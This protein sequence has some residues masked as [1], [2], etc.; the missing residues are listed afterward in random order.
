ME[1][2]A[3]SLSPSACSFL[4]LSSAKRAFRKTDAVQSVNG[5][6]KTSTFRVLS[7]QQVAERG[8]VFY[9][10]TLLNPR[11][12]AFSRIGYCPQF[13]ALYDELTAR[14]HLELLGRIHGYT[15]DSLDKVVEHLLET[16]DLLHYSNT[17]TA[18]F[19]GGTKRKLLMAQALIGDPHL[20][21]LDE[22][23]TGMDPNSR[24]Y[25]WEAVNSFV[26]R[27][28]A[29]V[30][31][32]HSI[33]ESEAL[34]GKLAIMEKSLVKEKFTEAFPKAVLVEDHANTLHF[35]LPPP[36]ILSEL[37][38]FTPLNVQEYVLSF[39]ISQNTLEQAFMSFVREQADPGKVSRS[40]YSI[41]T[42]DVC[43]VASTAT[44]WSATEMSCRKSFTST[45]SS[46]SCNSRSRYWKIMKPNTE[47]RDQKSSN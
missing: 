23:T 47:E 45:A 12:D 2:A 11:S 4:L 6:G 10:R 7:G 8:S 27:G 44:E 34:C 1:G 39:S 46:S 17:K 20:L 26:R 36:C 5:A 22:P 14:E 43:A 19:S 16:F 3:Y 42:G 9:G 21:L 37:F 40:V 28:N 30:L 35:E 33:P 18:F 24:L 31:T 38:E 32:T 13:D 25:L 15:S 29:V 41:S